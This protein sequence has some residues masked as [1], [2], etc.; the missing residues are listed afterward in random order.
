MAGEEDSIYLPIP[1]HIGELESSPITA[2]TSSVSQSDSHHESS[3]VAYGTQI[4]NHGQVESSK[5]VPGAHVTKGDDI[6]ES[7]PRLGTSISTVLS[8]T[9]STLRNNTKTNGSATSVGKDGDK[10]SPRTLTHVEVSNFRV[11][12]VASVPSRFPPSP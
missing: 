8:P 2:A 3:K 11:P 9:P 6:R 5:Q 10:S 4:N 1:D 12:G 7:S